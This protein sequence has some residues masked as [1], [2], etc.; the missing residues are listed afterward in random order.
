MIKLGKNLH[1]LSVVHG[2][3]DAISPLLRALKENES[4]ESLEI[5]FLFGGEKRALGSLLQE[6]TTI[7]SV[8]LKHPVNMA[9]FISLMSGL[10]HSKSLW[11]FSLDCTMLKEGHCTEMARMLVSNETLNHLVLHDAP[12]VEAGLPILAGALSMNQTLQQ[13]SITYPTSNVAGLHVR[14]CLRRNC[15]RMARSV[16]FVLAE[17]FSKNLTTIFPFGKRICHLPARRLPPSAGLNEENQGIMESL[18]A[19]DGDVY[20]NV[21]SLLQLPHCQFSVASVE[22]TFSTLRRLMT[23]LQCKMTEDRLRN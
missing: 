15:S 19:C 12:T 9:G 13:F 21:R 23:W 14:E 11:K 6:T 3:D 8:T 2:G 20:P 5:D 4:V 7:R 10:S 18:D 1:H 17:V 22:R 16:E